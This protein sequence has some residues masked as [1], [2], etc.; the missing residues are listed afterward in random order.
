MKV[1]DFKP[2]N[3]AT[4]WVYRYDPESMSMEFF[5]RIDDISAREIFYYIKDLVRVG[6]YIDI[7][8]EVISAVNPAITYAIEIKT[9]EIDRKIYFKQL[10]RMLDVD[11]KNEKM[12]N[13]DIL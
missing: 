8:E 2:I 13:I 3:N 5:E 1:I 4:I 6:G 9:N 10:K 12:Y 11:N 7:G